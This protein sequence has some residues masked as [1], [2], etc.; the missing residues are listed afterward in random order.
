[1]P[2][3]VLHGGLFLG[4]AVPQPGSSGLIWP[5]ALV[6][7][8]VALDLALRGAGPGWGR[9]LWRVLACTYPVGVVFAAVT[10]AWVVNTAHVYG[11]LSRPLAYAASWLGYGSLFGLEI[12]AFLGLPFLLTRRFPLWGLVLVPLWATVGQ[13]YLP[14]FLFFTYGQ[15]MFPLP[16]LVQP[17]DVLGSGGLNLLYLPLQLLLAAWV[18]RAYAPADAS[19]RSLGVAT[20]VVALLFAAA[21]GY[22]L[23]Q[24][25]VWALREAAGKPVELVGIQPN[26]SLQDLASNPALSHSRRQQSLRALLDDSAAALQKAQRRPQVPTVLLWPESVYPQPYFIA[27]GMREVVELWAQQARVHLL[28]SSVDATT[29]RGADGRAGR[30]VYGIAVHVPPQAATRGVYRKMALIPWGE[31]IP[32]ADWIPGYR[33]LLRAWIPQISEFTPGTEYTVFQAEGVGIAPLICF[34][35]AD[36]TVA[37]GMAAAGARVGVMLANLAWFGRTSVSN[38][39]G[40]YARF[41]AL[42]NRMPLLFLSQNG[43][44]FLI[45]SR[46]LDA[47]PRLP[48]FEAASTVLQ[49]RAPVETALY[50]R[51]GARVE[52]AYAVALLLGLAA[53][54]WY[55]R[56]R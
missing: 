47:S 55:R 49:V 42:E 56:G 35:A 8:F 52:A 50:S 6:P 19:L 36:R 31:T 53:F 37:R 46:G 2:L 17:A 24:M 40:L 21:A 11:G 23:R 1:M 30:Q 34:D 5:V 48:Q 9:R 28:L 25:D 18:R 16:A 27:R 45:N 38:Q 15:V 41:R 39:F 43:E 44:S 13:L 29:T 4:L 33:N 26:F 7:L 20:G 12:F 22:G 32:L 51:Y 14:R 3:L 10:G 54:A